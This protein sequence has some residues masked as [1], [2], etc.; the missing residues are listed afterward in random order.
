[1]PFDQAIPLLGI[2]P[3]EILASM[4]KDVFRRI[5]VTFLLVKPGNWKFLEYLPSVS[6]SWSIHIVD[7]LSIFVRKGYMCVFQ[8]A[9]NS[10]R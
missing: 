7:Y 1:M 4:C 5:L 9:Q 8:D 3:M 2:Y 10:H 6:Y